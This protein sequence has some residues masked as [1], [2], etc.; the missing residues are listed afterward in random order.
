MC[1]RPAPLL[2]FNTCTPL[3]DGAL[4]ESD[5]ALFL[6][7]DLLGIMFPNSSLQDILIR[8]DGEGVTLHNV[9]ATSRLGSSTK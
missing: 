9:E 8:R 6:I 5:E 7:G 4:T 2:L 1:G 3:M